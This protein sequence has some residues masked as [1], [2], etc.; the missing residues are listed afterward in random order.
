MRINNLIIRPPNFISLKRNV[1]SVLP[2]VGRNKLNIPIVSATFMF[3][4][5][6]S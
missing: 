2:F 4:G 6:L 3:A 1:I 5:L